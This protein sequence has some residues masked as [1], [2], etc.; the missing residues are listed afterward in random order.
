MVKINKLALIDNVLNY[1]EG[2]DDIIR[3]RRI[4]FIM[5]MEEKN[6]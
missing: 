3:V 1:I 6:Y 4:R 5:E 2:I